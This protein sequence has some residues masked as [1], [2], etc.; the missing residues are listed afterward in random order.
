MRIAASALVVVAAIGCERRAL[1]AD[2]GGGAGPI[3]LDAAAGTIGSDA[4]TIDV[5]PPLDA[6]TPPDAISTPDVSCGSKVTFRRHK[7]PIDMLLVVDRAVDRLTWDQMTGALIDLARALDTRYPY[8]WALKIFPEEGP[9]CGAGTVTS[10]IDV[11][12][13]DGDS[14]R[15]IAA[16]FA[17]P[18]AGN[19]RPTAAALTAARAYLAT[20]TDEIPKLMML[21]TAGAPTCAGTAGALT[22]DP[23]QAQ[24]DAIAAITPADGVALTF[25][26]AAGGVSPGADVDALNQ[27]AVAGGY[28]HAGLTAFFPSTDTTDLRTLLTLMSDTSCTFPVQP[29]PPY[30]SNRVSLNGS[31]IPYDNTRQNGWAY[32]D[33]SQTALSLYGRA[34]DALL[35]SRDAEL[36]IT[37]QCSLI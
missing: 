14:S 22:S 13:G 10:K 23:V 3:G 27:L 29:L 6:L 20:V 7:D 26:M 37:Y 21:V 1:Q 36:V 9:A 16:L 8:R 19:G 31:E 34:C 33:E 24:A 25:V 11:P 5:A 30:V 17:A 32:T 12:F 15:V 18:P 28:V 2:G 4:R 35:S